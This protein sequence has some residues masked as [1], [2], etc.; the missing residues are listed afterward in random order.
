MIDLNYILKYFYFEIF[1]SF[2]ME[3]TNNNKEDQLIIYPHTI[4]ACIFDV[5]GTVLDTLPL[6]WKANSLTM[7]IDFPPEFQPNVNGCSDI[8][9]ANIIIN[10]FN[11]NMTP[12]Y[13]IKTRISHLKHLLPSSPLV[14]GIESIIRHVNSMGLPMAVATS[15]HR[16][17]YEAKISKHKDLFDLFGDKIVC[18]NEIKK[19]KPS[20]EIFLKALDHINEYQK[21]IKQNFENLKPENVLVFE[22]AAFGAKAAFDGGFPSVILKASEGNTLNSKLEKLKVKPVLIVDSFKDFKFE[23]FIWEVPN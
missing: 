13:F 23:Q 5:D 12:E 15:S 1:I 4:K 19:G 7:G 3:P 21:K 6:Y 2:L 20:P 10:H 16:D 22:D 11:L 9:E 17:A 18:G 8:D 14:P